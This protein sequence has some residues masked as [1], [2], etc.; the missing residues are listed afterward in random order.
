[1]SRRNKGGS[2]GTS[3]GISSIEKP[4]TKATHLTFSE[5]KVYEKM[6]F[7]REREKVDPVYAE[8]LKLR[9]QLAASNSTRSSHAKKTKVSLPKFSWDKE[10][11]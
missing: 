5:R 2:V 4:N 11:E 10:A 1:M 6:R 8:Y 9:R 7:S 3:C